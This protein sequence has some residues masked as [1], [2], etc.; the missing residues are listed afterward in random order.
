MLSKKRKIKGFV[1]DEA[2]IGVGPKHVWLWVAIEPKHK[3][4]PQVDMSFE[5]TTLLWLSDLLHP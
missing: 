3:Q 5:G 1:I 4:I 2:L